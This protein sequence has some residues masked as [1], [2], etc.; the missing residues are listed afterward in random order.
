[1]PKCFR[2][3]NVMLREGTFILTHSHLHYLQAFF[4]SIACRF[5]L[6]N[7]NER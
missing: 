7:L 3:E 1:M 6:R 4:L 5:P 2:G